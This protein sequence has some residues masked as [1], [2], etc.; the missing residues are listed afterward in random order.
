MGDACQGDKDND[1]ITD[2]EDVCPLNHEISHTDFSQ[3]QTISLDPG[4]D[5]SSQSDPVWK[6]LDRVRMSPTIYK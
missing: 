5:G 2:T 3:F 6:I 1:G 4:H